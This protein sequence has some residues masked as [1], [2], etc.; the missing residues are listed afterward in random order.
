MRRPP[1]APVAASTTWA[2]R[3][4]TAHVWAGAVPRRALLGHPAGLLR[5]RPRRASED[6]ALRSGR[7]GAAAGRDRGRHRRAR[8]AGRCRFAARRG[9]ARSG[10]TRTTAIV[11]VLLILFC[12]AQAPELVGRD[13]RYRCCRSTSREPWRRTDY[14][15]AK[16]GGLV[17]ALFLVDIA[18]ADRALRRPGARRAATCARASATRSAPCRAS[19]SR[20]R[21]SPACSAACRD[22]IAAYTPRRAYATA[23]II[24]VFIVSPIIVALVDNLATSDAGPIHHL[25][26]RARYPR[27]D[28]CRDLRVVLGQPGRRVARSARLD[29]RPGRGRRHRRKHRADDPSIPPDPA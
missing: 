23:A 9:I 20:A 17:L 27:R 5:D 8:G 26:E 11:S 19:S 18:A 4:T 12:G 3:A 7:A 22:V 2:T 13:Q 21:S 14:A 28:Q 25:P 29:L 1:V 6:R 10:T 15:L 24:A 16:L